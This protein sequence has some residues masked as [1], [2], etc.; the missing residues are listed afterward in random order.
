MDSSTIVSR[1]DA[2]GLI[3]L[4]YQ[5]AI[6]ACSSNRWL[7]GSKQRRFSQIELN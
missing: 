7:G 1:A 4:F 5:E 3:A 2:M 6:V